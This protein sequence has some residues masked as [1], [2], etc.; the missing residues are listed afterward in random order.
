[1]KLF[2]MHRREIPLRGGAITALVTPFRNGSIDENAFRTHVDW[3]IGQG[4]HGLV[5]CG[6]TGESPTLA[7]AER[8]RLIRACVAGRV[9]VIAGVGTNA[10]EST[11]VQARAAQ[12]AG[13]DAALVVTPYYNRPSQE[14]LCQHFEAVATAVDLPIILYNVPRRCG[15]GLADDSIARLAEMPNIIGLKEAS[16]ETERPARLSRRLPAGFFLLSGEDKTA[17]AFGLAGGHGCIS[18]IGNIAPRLC[19]CLQAAVLQGDFTRAQEIQSALDPLLAA[20]ALESNPGPIK[21]ALSLVRRGF[22]PEVRLPLVQVMPETAAA[23]RR[24]LD[25]LVRASREIAAA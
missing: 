2:P 1:M 24:G 3:Q 8:Y 5:P 22:S 19:V 4:I 14:G 23:I 6:T 9:P 25:S 16:D 7:Q 20:L 15:V 11:I 12:E 10:T 13:A 17:I 18:V 21:Y